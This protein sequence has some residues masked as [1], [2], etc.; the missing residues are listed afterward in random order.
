MS[1]EILTFMGIPGA[2]DAKGARAA[3]LGIP[4]ECAGHRVRSGAHLGPDAI[5]RQSRL[6]RPYQ[7]PHA[8]FDPLTRT[9]VKDLGNLDVA[10]VSKMLAKVLAVLLA[11]FL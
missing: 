11:A 7:P 9:A 4:F 8:D 3:I 5:R 6:L 10:G 1:D 2:T